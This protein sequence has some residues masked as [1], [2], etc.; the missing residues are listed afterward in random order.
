MQLKWLEDFIVFSETRNF[1]RAAEL[2]HVTHPA[3]GRRLRSLEQ[4]VGAALIDRARYPAALTPEGESFLVSARAA[5][6]ALR[7]G[8]DTVN[9]S[10]R[11]APN[12]VR[13][14]TG[15]TLAATHFPK[16][17]VRVQQKIG[18]FETT[19]FTG[20]VSDAIERLS[21]GHADFAL[22]F[23]HPQLAVELDAAR[24]MSIDIASETLVAVAAKGSAFKLPGTAKS[25]VPLLRLAP[26]LAMAHIV[27]ARLGSAPRIHT[28]TVQT[29]DFALT[30]RQFALAGLGVA[31]LPLSIVDDDI[32]RGALQRFDAQYDLPL[33]VKLL[34]ASHNEN[35]LLDK[36]WEASKL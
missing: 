22:T 4:W 25:P 21:E 9:A 6:A 13:I 8:R 27:E 1:S 10:V 17:L 7:T 32:R 15:T 5:V 14:A 34:C 23:G 20:S 18:V 31:W 36:I 26:S 3:F 33:M 19:V 30:V 2:R 28:K 35:R 11:G 24:F 12:R 16:W 29:A